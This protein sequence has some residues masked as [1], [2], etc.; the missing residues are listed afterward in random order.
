MLYS[1]Q[2]VNT[3]CQFVY[4]TCFDS[5]PPPDLPLEE[6]DDDQDFEIK[7]IQR[8]VYEILFT[9]GDSQCCSDQTLLFIIRSFTECSNLWVSDNVGISGDLLV[10]THSIGQQDD[11]TERFTVVPVVREKVAKHVLKLLFT[12]CNQTNLASQEHIRLAQLATAVLIKRCLGTL[13]LWY[14][15]KAAQGLF[16]LPR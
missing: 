11:I 10:G 6:V 2:K 8:L 9:V 15:D 14:N 4:L 13:A 1:F 7:W 3:S 5:L 12:F 16:P